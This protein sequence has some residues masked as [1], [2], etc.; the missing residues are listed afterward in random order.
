MPTTAHPTPGPTRLQVTVPIS[1]AFAWQGNYH[2]VTVFGHLRREDLPELDSR[3]CLA[4]SSGSATV[5]LR[6]T[7]AELIALRDALQRAIDTFPAAAAASPAL[8]EA[9]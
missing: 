6:P 7:R 2:E 4:I 5:N 9:A 3:A 8:A 1:A